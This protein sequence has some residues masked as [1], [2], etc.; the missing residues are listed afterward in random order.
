MKTIKTNF[1]DKKDIFN[2]TQGGATLESLKG[3]VIDVLGYV[4]CEKEE[5]GNPV[6]VVTFKLSDGTFAG[7]KSATAIGSLYAYIE[8][9]GED[10][11]PV[12]FEIVS[13]KAKSGREFLQ[14]NVV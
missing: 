7:G 4:V 8:T 11:F 9:F 2:A 10:A 5:E 12:S 13:G 14:L 1:T 3:N 6:T